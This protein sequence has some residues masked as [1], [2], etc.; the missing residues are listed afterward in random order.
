MID[1]ATLEAKDIGTWVKYNPTGE[2][3]RIK[4]FSLR[5]GWVYVVF[6]CGGEWDRYKEFTAAACLPR[7]LS[8][9]EEEEK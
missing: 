7:H 9:Y 6:K 3:G 8:F 2:K 4:S 5:A 1:I